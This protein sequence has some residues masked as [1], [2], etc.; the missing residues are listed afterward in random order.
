MTKPTEILLTDQD[1]KRAEALKLHGLVA[2]W[3]ELTPSLAPWVVSLIEWE[4]VE[5]NR[6]GLERRLRNA[7]IGRFKSLSDFDW[8]W[9]KQLDR[10]A[11]TDLMTLSF[12]KAA[13]NAVFVGPNGV[14]KSMV[15]QNIAYHAVLQGHPVL[16]TTAAQM[17]NVLAS[18]D[19]DNALR[20]RLKYYAQPQ[21]LVIDEVGYLSYS[22]RHADLLF[23]IINRRYEEKSTLVTTNK[24]FS[25]W[26][27][28]FPNASCVVSL[29]DRLIHHAE[30]I[31]FDAKS[32]RMK[33]A[34]ERA[35]KKRRG[36]AKPRQTKTPRTKNENP[37]GEKHDD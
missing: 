18:L 1:K 16:F 33:E 25:E 35:D 29:I 32:Y 12:I 3:N 23:E 24:P 11:I 22:N 5:R 27:E 36:K 8:G 30:I 15:A 34:R 4:E 26:G 2:H 6:R 9:P 17:L 14:G 19:G 7:H 28:V 21:L 37:S 13:E 10:G 20:R 31:S